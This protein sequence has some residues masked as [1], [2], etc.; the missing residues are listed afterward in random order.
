MKDGRGT[1][2][3]INVKVA[4]N[5]SG[6]IAVGRIV[7]LE[8]GV[9]NKWGTYDYKNRP[10]ITIARETHLNQA[11]KVNSVVRDPSSVLVLFEGD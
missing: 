1:P 10:K 4:F 7:D 2:L 9:L 8:D 6:Q 11:T 5:F 3:Q